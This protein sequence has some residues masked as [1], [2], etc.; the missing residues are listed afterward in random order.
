MAPPHLQDKGLIAE[1]DGVLKTAYEDLRTT[2]EQLEDLE[3]EICRLIVA[4]IT[5]FPDQ[6]RSLHR[7]PQYISEAFQD[8]N[9]M[10]AQ[11]LEWAACNDLLESAA[12]LDREL[13]KANASKTIFEGLQN[14]LRRRIDKLSRP[15]LR[16]LNILDLP[17]EMLLRIFELVEEFVPHLAYS[18]YY[19]GGAGRKA[20]A[21][22]RLVCRQFCNV[23]SQLLVRMVRV[24]FNEPS[25]A[26]LDEISRHPTIAKGVRAVRVVLHFHNSSFNDLDTFISYQTDRLA[27]AVDV[28]E[29]SWKWGHSAIPEQTASEMITNGRVVVSTLRRMVSADTDSDGGYLEDDRSRRA[30]LEGI[31]RE[32]L[33]LLEKQASRKKTGEFCRLVGSAIAR[34]PSARRLEFTDTD[35]E[36]LEG[37]RLIPGTDVWSALY[38]VMLQPMTGYHTRAYGFELPDYECIIN[39][40]EAVRNAGTLL[41]SLDIQLSTLACPTGLVPAPDIRREFSSGMQQLEAFSFKYSGNADDQDVSD[42][43]EFL[44]TCLDTASL[45]RLTLD[46]RGSE[47]ESPTIDLG[48]IMGSMSRHKL[49]HIFLRYV[50]VDVSKLKLLLERLPP[51]MNCI[52][53]MNLCLLSGTWKVALDVL[54]RKARVITFL[55]DPRGAEC[56]SMS[57]EDYE[58]IFGH[59]DY[60][61]SSEAEMYVNHYLM[62]NPPNPIQVLEDELFTA[63]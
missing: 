29:D 46:M 8:Q 49:T 54:R 10:T 47:A 51:S 50:A 38:P 61:R 41:S 58:R 57:Q 37:P 27:K 40:I 48:Q 2:N 5:W 45:Q 39:V 25:L 21:N 15:T 35:F 17:N 56:D 19:Y 28:F 22:T 24:N 3:R 30:H 33:T 43:H 7:P 26:R 11:W 62:P 16:S 9:L 44:S 63:H 52:L 55:T 36:S 60:A 1:S 53:Q 18:A 59:E 32:Y 14:A 42:L 31:H 23:S 20:I 34:M 6:S 4:K 12:N 13:E